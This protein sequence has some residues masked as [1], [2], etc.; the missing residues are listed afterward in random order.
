MHI[1]VMKIKNWYVDTKIVENPKIVAGNLPD[2]MEITN[3][4][5]RQT[6]LEKNKIINTGKNDTQY[7]IIVNFSK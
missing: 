4:G 3:K 6:Y 1:L 5:S 7:K 2:R